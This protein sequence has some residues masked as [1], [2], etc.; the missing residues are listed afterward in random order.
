MKTLTC[1]AEPDSIPKEE[2]PCHTDNSAGKHEDLDV[3]AINLQADDGV[4][5]CESEAG[6]ET[7]IKHPSRLPPRE[8][9]NPN[10]SDRPGDATRLHRSPA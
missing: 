3:R 9:M 5:V 1:F 4:F 8:P 10:R 2:L 7:A 6:S